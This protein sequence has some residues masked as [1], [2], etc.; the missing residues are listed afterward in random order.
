MPDDPFGEMVKLGEEIFERTAV[1]PVSG[2]YVG[3]TLTCGA[4]HLDT[5]RLADSAP[6]W[7]AWDVAAYMKSQ[8]RPQGPRFTG[9]LAETSERFHG[10]RFDCCGKR[11]GPDGKLLGTPVS[12]EQP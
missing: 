12:A 5:G 4:C 6:M 10:S 1:H 7:A 8:E 3:N 9:D 2:H 11:K